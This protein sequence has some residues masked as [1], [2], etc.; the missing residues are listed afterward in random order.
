MEQFSDPVTTASSVSQYHSIR[1]TF[2]VTMFFLLWWEKMQKCIESK[3][4]M[5]TDITESRHNLYSY[6]YD[7][8]IAIRKVIRSTKK[9]LLKSFRFHAQIPFKKLQAWWPSTRQRDSRDDLKFLQNT[10]TIVDI[11][12]SSLW[13]TYK[14]VWHGLMDSI[15]AHFISPWNDPFFISIPLLLHSEV[16]TKNTISIQKRK[17]IIDSCDATVMYKIW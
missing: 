12:C 11:C 17:N 7:L 15:L 10:V 8:Q 9:Q 4:V 3:S 16:L 5:K 6:R 1:N 14:T 13:Y 2:T